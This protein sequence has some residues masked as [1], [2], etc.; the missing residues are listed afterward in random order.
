[1][2]RAT[3]ERGPEGRR[4]P[5]VAAE[6]SPH[7]ADLDVDTLRAYRQRLIAEEER[8]SYWRRLVHGRMDLLEAGSHVE[9][10]LTVEQLVRALGETGAG[11]SRTALLRVRSAGPLPELPELSEIW[12]NE[13]DPHDPDA[14]GSA[15]DRLREAEKQL[16]DYRHALHARLDE[17]TGEL[18]VRYRANPADALR[19][20]P[21]PATGANRA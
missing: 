17:A 2:G 8:A 10:T 20:L 7:L 4:R 5:V 16:T 9:G 12:D 15:L 14:V 13:V 21:A 19:A 11:A 18:I 1:M 3:G 6:A